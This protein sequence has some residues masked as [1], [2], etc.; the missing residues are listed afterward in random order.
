MKKQIAIFCGSHKA[1][2]PLFEIEIE[3]LGALMARQGRTLIY[4]GSN[5]GYMGTISNPFVAADG[6]IVAIIP[7]LFP[8]EVIYSQPA[9]K[10]VVVENMQQRK[11][12]MLQ[13]ADA[14][15][16]L[17]GGV[18]TLDE[19]TEILS[20]IQLGLNHQPV[21][22]LNIE[23]FFDPFLQQLQLMVSEGLMKQE[24]YNTILVA[25]TPPEVLDKIDGWNN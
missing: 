19:L 7:N 14:F 18:G 10:L 3:K 25:P 11:Q 20:A 23:G 21:A 9:T 13:Q 24:L 5:K 15:I 4:G 17:P 1:A 6:E 8:N 2:N 12:L 22:L 16:A